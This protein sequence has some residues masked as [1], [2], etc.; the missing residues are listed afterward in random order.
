MHNHCASPTCS[1]L[2]EY[3]GVTLVKQFN[4]GG[5]HHSYF[6]SLM[7]RNQKKM[8][9]IRGA[10]EAYRAIDLHFFMPKQVLVQLS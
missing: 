1:K 6:I 8:H 7:L 3:R 5:T 9:I 2:I 4:G 10:Y